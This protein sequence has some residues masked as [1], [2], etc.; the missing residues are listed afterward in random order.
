MGKLWV[1]KSQNYLSNTLSY[2]NIPK[3]IFLL[4]FF[5]YF[6]LTFLSHNYPWQRSDIPYFNYMA[7]AFLHGQFH[8]RLEPPTIHD[9]VILDGKLLAYWAPFPDILFTPFILLFGINFS[10]IF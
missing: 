1:K 8:F 3:K 9:L 5:C 10:D 4:V 7:D 6:S 2:F